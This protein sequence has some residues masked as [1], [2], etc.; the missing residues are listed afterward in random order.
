MEVMDC[1][2][3]KTENFFR[4]DQVANVSAGKGP[5]SGASTFFFDWAFV[6]TVGVVLQVDRS[7]FG[8]CRAASGEPRREHTIKH[9]YSSS[10]HLHNL[11]RGREPH[12]V[13]RR[14]GGKERFAEL[15]RAHHFG[16]GF[17]DAY[18]ADRIAIEFHF[19]Q[20][21][22]ALFA[23]IAIGRSLNDAEKERTRFIGLAGKPAVA[24][25]RPTPRACS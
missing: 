18:A 5:A 8:E 6:E 25:P 13:A 22:S 14:L 4:F 19:D 24:K 20:G 10:D 15:D 7:D 16:L 11:R 23:Q 3:A 9:V 2:Q 12:G 21:A 1:N 17:A